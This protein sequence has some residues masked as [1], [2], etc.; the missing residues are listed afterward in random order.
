MVRATNPGSLNYEGNEPT[1]SEAHLGTDWVQGYYVG[2]TSSSV[3]LGKQNYGY[4][5]LKSAKLPIKIGT[6]YTLKVVCEGANLKIYV[7]DELYIDYTDPSPFMQGMVGVR[8]NQCS[9]T[10]DN[11]KVSP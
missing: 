5:A 10:F 6:T 7:D 2:L 4:K 11:L 3:I 9:A 1:D 8:T